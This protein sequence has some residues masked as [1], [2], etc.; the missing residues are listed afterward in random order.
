MATQGR[1]S[2]KICFAEFEL[3]LETGESTGPPFSS[4][5]NLMNDIVDLLPDLVLN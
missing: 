4:R 1:L 2:K 5:I 3:D